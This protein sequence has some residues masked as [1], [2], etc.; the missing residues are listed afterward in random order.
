[1]MPN[2]F[3]EPPK[4]S[5]SESLRIKDVFVWVEIER[6]VLAWGEALRGYLVIQG[7]Q[8]PYRIRNPVIASLGHRETSDSEVLHPLN[9]ELVLPEGR[10]V[11]PNALQYFP[12]ELFVPNTTPFQ[13]A[14]ELSLPMY[15]PDGPGPKLWLKVVPPVAC[16]V[17]ATQFCD[18]TQMRLRDWVRSREGEVMGWFGSLDEQAP[19]KEATLK[20]LGPR[21]PW[22]GRLILVRRSR[23]RWWYGDKVYLDLPDFARDP[24]TIREQFEDVLRQAGFRPGAAG[25]LPLPA[26]ARRVRLDE[27]PLPSDRQPPPDPRALN[28]D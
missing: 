9:S 12:F 15:G 28:G 22:H 19:F 14:V 18:L 23:W 6:S 8:S 17:I 25:N 24:D 11:Q 20:L 5:K 10:V 13:H 27:L 16:T 3:P 26:D 1:M 21:H 2:E 4:I 7:G